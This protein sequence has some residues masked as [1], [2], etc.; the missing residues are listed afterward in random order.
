MAEESSMSEWLEGATTVEKLI[1]L[2]VLVA[3]LVTPVM[4]AVEAG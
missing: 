1:F 2:S 4:V 3:L